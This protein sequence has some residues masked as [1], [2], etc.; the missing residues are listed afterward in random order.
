MSAET[1]FDK[2]IEELSQKRDYYKSESTK[3]NYQNLD[4]AVSYRE[5]LTTAINEIE[6]MVLK[7]YSDARNVMFLVKS[8]SHFFRLHFFNRRKDTCVLEI[9]NTNG[10]FRTLKKNT[11][12]I[13]T[14]NG[15]EYLYPVSDSELFEILDMCPNPE[16]IVFSCKE[17]LVR[18]LEKELQSRKEEYEKQVLI[19]VKMKESKKLIQLN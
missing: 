17:Q 11:V 8:G 16:V 3:L 19:A 10:K 13:T 15:L 14:T 1:E 5:K 2:R 4:D 7:H 12:S 18:M 9:N 6:K